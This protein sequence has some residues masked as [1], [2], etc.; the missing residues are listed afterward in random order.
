MVRPTLDDLPDAALPEGLEIRDV[1]PEHMEAIYEAE[2]EAFREHW[3]Q[4]APGVNERARFFDD[5]VGPTRRCGGSRGTATGSPG[6]VRS[7]IHAAQNERSGGSAAGSSTSASAGRGAAVA[8]ARA[9]IA[10]SFPLLRARGM[11]EGALGVDTQ[12]EFG[13]PRLYEAVRLPHGEHRAGVRA[14][15]RGTLSRRTLDMTHTV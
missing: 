7:F 3:G 8:L 12:N 14:H 10:A 2:S 1:R 4:P 15:A 13:A 11:T 6:S 5:P 9:L